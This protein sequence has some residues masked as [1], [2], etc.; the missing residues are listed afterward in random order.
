MTLNYI[1]FDLNFLKK[2]A[3]YWCLVFGA[4]STSPRTVQHNTISSGLEGGVGDTI[5]HTQSGGGGVL[6][7]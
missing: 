4:L 5:Q 7:R 3:L 1:Q 6:K 2:K